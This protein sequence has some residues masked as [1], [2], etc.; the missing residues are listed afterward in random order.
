MLWKELSSGL[1][2]KFKR[3]WTLLSYCFALRY[4]F[5]LKVKALY[6]CCFH[7]SWSF[8]FKRPLKIYHYK[9]VSARPYSIIKSYGLRRQRIFLGSRTNVDI[10]PT[11]NGETRRVS[12]GRRANVRKSLHSISLVSLLIH[13][14]LGFVSFTHLQIIFMI[15]M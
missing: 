14:S 5:F 13:S 9:N 7:H 11:Q 15:K 1:G 3:P 4:T 10:D 12:R 8:H 2:T 6:R